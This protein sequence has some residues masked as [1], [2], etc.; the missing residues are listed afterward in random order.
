M[1]E[2]RDPMIHKKGE[3]ERSNVQD[4]KQC[5][6]LTGTQR[7]ESIRERERE[8]DREKKNRMYNPNIRSGNRMK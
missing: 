1:E 8:R 3:N 5:V 2:T 4:S 6:C 7:N